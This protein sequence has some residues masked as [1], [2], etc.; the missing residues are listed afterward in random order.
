MNATARLAILLSGLALAMP[1]HAATFV[2][3][4]LGDD[5]DANVGDG[6]CDIPTGGPPRCTL[7]AAIQEAN[8][9]A[10]STIDTIEFGLGLIVISITSA[11]PTI[12]GNT[13]IDGRTAPG[14]NASA[15]STL[16]A[17]PSVYIDGS[18]IGG[19]TADGLRVNGATLF[20]V[21]GLGITG[22]PD[23]GIEL[24]GS[25]ADRVDGNWI[26]VGR[27]GG[28]AGNGGAGV[29]LN[30]CERCIVGQRITDGPSPVVEGLGNVI[31]NNGEDGIYVILG[32]DNLIAGNHI[33]VN[34]VGSADHGNGRHGIWLVGASNRIGQFR[35]VGA[36]LSLTTPN[37]I[38]DNGGDGIRT[39]TGG[40]L[41][42][43]NQIFGNDGNG[44]ALNGASS[45]LGFVNPGMRNLIQGNG[46][47][48]VVIG[49]LFAS[50][51]NLVQLNWIY[52]NFGRGVQISNGGST[53]I[54]DNDIFDNDNDAVRVD[55]ADNSVRSNRIGVFNNF[56]VGNAANGVVVNAGNTTVAGNLIG[57]VADDG[58][59]VVSGSGS[60]I[61]NNLIGTSATG[62][63]V[64]NA[65]AGI[66]VR[67]GAANTLISGN[68][69]GHNGDGIHLEG[70]GTDVCENR[71]GIGDDDGDIGNAIEGIRVT[72]GGNMIG[73]VGVGCPGNL[74]SHNASDGIEIAGDANVVRNNTIGG[75]PGF[76]TG[77]GRGGVLLTTGADFNELVGNVIQYNGDAGVRVGALAGTR[78]RIEANQFRANADIAI[79]LLDDGVTP[80]DAG[81]SD[82][83]PN[84]LQNFPVLL[85]VLGGVGAVEVS[86][87][88]D[89]QLA[90]SNYPIQVDFHFSAVNA[91]EGQRVYSDL[92]SLS[93]GATRTV[94][95]DTGETSG[96]LTAVAIDLEGNTSEF[97]APVPFSQLPLSGDIFRDGF[98]D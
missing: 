2:V 53:E 65:V 90:V 89:S 69:I 21:Y 61:E 5:A 7:R 68:T 32:D 20:N 64:G 80:N 25:V 92:Y 60:T 59:D 33:G 18:S 41:I 76:P 95:F 45:R 26:G 83:G 35:G 29:Y 97:S 24:V 43:T 34:P 73:H 78:N 85:G 63:D 50:P 3:S 31:S 96:F 9:N 47:H 19:T 10:P 11:L 1:A 14:F 87:Q 27:S 38:V 72:G 36:D 71:I 94:S 6:I 75:T 91:R 23:N 84:N 48:G 77:N 82:T 4:D 56:G 81:D 51:D 22:F 39:S 86:Y 79:D 46:G 28:I 93:P 66:R 52:Q 17:P 57:A 74:I 49:N 88:I 8:A 62:A 42:Y 30:D 98:E 15:T 12:T 44:V 54:L 70:S 37:F 16:D 58:I 55:S 67:L 13:I 40:Q